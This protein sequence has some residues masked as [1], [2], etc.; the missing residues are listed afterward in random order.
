MSTRTIELTRV[1]DRTFGNRKHPVVAT[2]REQARALDA[3]EPSDMLP[4]ARKRF[5]QNLLRACLMV[6]RARAAS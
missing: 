5:T 3:A 1:V 4:A 2:L 6:G